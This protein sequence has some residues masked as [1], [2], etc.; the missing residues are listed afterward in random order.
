MTQKII[1]LVFMVMPL[2]ALADISNVDLSLGTSNTKKNVKVF[3]KN[4]KLS[5]TVSTTN[6]TKK[7]YDKNN[8]L[9]KEAF[10]RR[11]TA[12]HS[13]YSNAPNGYRFIP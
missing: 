5:R 8:R 6:K 9:Q 11:I 12:W 7:F 13:K 2:L 3:D 10:T 4:N 1:I